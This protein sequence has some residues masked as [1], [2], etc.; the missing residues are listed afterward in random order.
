VDVRFPSTKE[1]SEILNRTTGVVDP[2]AQVVV[3]GSGILDMQKLARKIPIA[4]RVSNYVSRLIVATH[5]GESPSPLVN[6]YVRYGASP[7]GGQALVLGSKIMAL[8]SG[9]YN[10]SFDD[11]ETVA[12]AALRHRLLLNFEGQAAGIRTDDIIK[13]LIDHIN[14]EE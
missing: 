2:Q 14:Q 9:R 7:R 11:V 3:D 8:I 1:L 10:V 12:M 13:D 5:P 4:S 6:Q